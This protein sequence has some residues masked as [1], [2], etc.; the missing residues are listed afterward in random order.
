[1]ESISRMCSLNLSFDFCISLLFWAK[2]QCSVSFACE[3]HHR[4]RLSETLCELAI[5]NIVEMSVGVG[6]SAQ[7][8]PSNI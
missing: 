1:M 2:P 4:R 3:C 6:G 7:R 5:I 8:A